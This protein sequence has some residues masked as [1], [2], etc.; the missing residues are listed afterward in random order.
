MDLV[1][2]LKVTGLV[3]FWKMAYFRIWCVKFGHSFVVEATKYK[4]QGL[5]ML[6]TVNI[7]LLSA[8]QI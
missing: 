3:P 8:D 4:I 1:C 6:I 7:L 2:W 5:H